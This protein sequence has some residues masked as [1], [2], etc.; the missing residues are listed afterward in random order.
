MKPVRISKVTEYTGHYVPGIVSGNF[1]F[2]SGQLS[3]DPFT[4]KV[5]VGGIREHM[6]QALQNVDLVLKEA[7]LCLDNVVH[8]RIYIS[9]IEHWDEV[10][11]VY[12]EFFGEHKPA[13]VVVP[14]GNLHFGCL[15][16]IEAIAEY[17]TEKVK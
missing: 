2:V 5:P 3:I 1:L 15:V 9:D 8:C 17:S 10:N 6:E 7:G 12:R 4:R 11:E 14:T 13:R 16:E